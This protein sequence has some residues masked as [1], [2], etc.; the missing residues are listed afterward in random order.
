MVFFRSLIYIKVK[1]MLNINLL[2]GKNKNKELMLFQS[3]EK[4]ISP[5]FIV[6]GTTAYSR[7]GE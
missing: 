6:N 3:S 7:G 1:I 2:I 4:D 5:K